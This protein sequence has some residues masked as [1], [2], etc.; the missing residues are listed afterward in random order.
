MESKSSTQ[1]T[2]NVKLRVTPAQKAHIERQ[3]EQLGLTVSTYLRALAAGHE[4]RTERL[5]GPNM[6]Q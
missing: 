3:A 1:Y 5:D 2:E 4:L 6:S